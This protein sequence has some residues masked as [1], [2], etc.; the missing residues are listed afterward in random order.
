MQV[1]IGFPAGH[2]KRRIHFKKIKNK[3]KRRLRVNRNRLLYLGGAKRDRTADLL[4]AIPFFLVLP[5]LTFLDFSCKILYI[6]M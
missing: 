6:R 1:F 4:N 5:L 3:Q 2:V